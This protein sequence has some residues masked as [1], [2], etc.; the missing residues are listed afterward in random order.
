MRPL[1]GVACRR[2]LGH[3]LLGEGFSAGPLK[4]VRY[5]RTGQAP[6]KVA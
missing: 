3:G 5:L 1:R 6:E 4:W 2:Q